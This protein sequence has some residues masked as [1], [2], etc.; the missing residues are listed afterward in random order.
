MTKKV[1]ADVNKFVK[2]KKIQY[3]SNYI[4]KLYS[5]TLPRTYYL[6]WENNQIIMYIESENYFNSYKTFFFLQNQYKIAVD[7]SIIIRII[8]MWGLC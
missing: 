2:F 1:Y 3:K 8:Y 6:N 4:L 5:N 7:F